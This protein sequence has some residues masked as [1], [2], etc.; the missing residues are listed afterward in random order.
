MQLLVLFVF[1]HN[2][3]GVL[4]L[5]ISMFCISVQLN[6]REQFIDWKQTMGGNRKPPQKRGP[7]ECLDQFKATTMEE[8]DLKTEGRT[9]VTT[10]QVAER[11]WY[12][13]EAW[14][15]GGLRIKN[16]VKDEAGM[17]IDGATPSK[18]VKKEASK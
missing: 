1:I 13:P 8:E 12:T 9:K 7:R 2:F 6:L 10:K 18:R 14:E 17:D 16:E 11:T 5:C 4:L 3:L 15:H